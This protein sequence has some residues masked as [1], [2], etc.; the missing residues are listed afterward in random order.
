MNDMKLLIVSVIMC[1]AICG[2]VN[3]E[4]AKQENDAKSNKSV[5]SVKAKRGILHYGYGGGNALSYAL[6]LTHSVPRHHGLTPTVYSNL[7]GLYKNVLTPT[8]TYALSHGG[9]SVQS[10]NVNYPKY[11]FIQPRPIVHFHPGRPVVIAQP[12]PIHPVA[13]ATTARPIIPVSYPVYAN[14]GPFVYQKPIF[15]QRPLVPAP[16]AVP[17]VPGITV[18][19][20]VAQVPH[21]HPIFTPNFNPLTS[22]A[23]QSVHPQ[24]I[25]TNSIGAPSLFNIQPG[26]WRPIVG[27][28]P[29]PP[30]P[31]TTAGMNPVNP[32]PISLLPPISVGTP[33]LSSSPSDAQPSFATPKFPNFYLTPTEGASLEQV[34]QIASQHQSQQSINNEELT[35]SRGKLRTSIVC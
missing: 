2:A 7:P 29:I 30:I 24:S 15:F 25:P 13:V 5:S 31:T 26:G 19:P 20:A 22:V 32:P 33:S 14:R 6:P 35:P 12:M 8:T 17:L 1:S 23:V 11:N 3:C 10:Y 21:Y 16:T 9:A 4:S 18:K 34:N 28:P 27:Y